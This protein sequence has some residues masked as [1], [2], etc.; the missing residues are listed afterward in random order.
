MILLG[1]VIL[2]EMECVVV[3]NLDD[4]R[5]QFRS[6]LC[7]L[8]ERERL[9]IECELLSELKQRVLQAQ[10]QFDRIGGQERIDQIVVSLENLMLDGD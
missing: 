2:W 8:D 10:M 9:K 3:S 7:N 6:C 5:R 1:I 4:L